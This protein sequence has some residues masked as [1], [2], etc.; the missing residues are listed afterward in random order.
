MTSTLPRLEKHQIDQAIVIHVG[1]AEARIVE[2]QPGQGRC[3]D[4]GR[5]EVP[6]QVEIGTPA[7]D[8]AERASTRPSQ[9][10]S[11]QRSSDEDGGRFNGAVTVRAGPSP[12]SW[13]GR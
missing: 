2:R 9:S 3:H 10:R 8:L 5:A 4:D 13:A 12:P 7:V 11:S 1:E 6:S